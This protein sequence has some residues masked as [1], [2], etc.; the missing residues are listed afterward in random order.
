MKNKLKEIFC[1]HKFEPDRIGWIT[2][3]FNGDSCTKCGKLDDSSSMIYVNLILIFA[4]FIV[5]I[6]FINEFLK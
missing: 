1:I 2:N 5:F 6:L 4:L 3:L